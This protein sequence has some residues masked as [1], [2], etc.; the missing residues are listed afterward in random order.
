[1]LD[2][3]VKFKGTMAKW[4]VQKHRQQETHKTLQN[5]HYTWNLF[6]VLFLYLIYIKLCRV[7]VFL[8]IHEMLKYTYY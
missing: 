7:M 5:E 3:R 6:F 2:V 1:M 8:Q 4:A